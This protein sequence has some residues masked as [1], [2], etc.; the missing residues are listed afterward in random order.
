MELSFPGTY[1]LRMEHNRPMQILTPECLIHIH[2]ESGV[3][4]GFPQWGPAT[5]SYDK[6]I[7]QWGEMG[8]GT[9]NE[10]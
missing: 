9:W 8:Q 6:G 2:C 3:V 5:C 1:I 10:G 7:P 4:L